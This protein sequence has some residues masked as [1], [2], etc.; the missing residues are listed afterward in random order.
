MLIQIFKLIFQQ[1]QFFL[2]LLLTLLLLLLPKLT[3]KDILFLELVDFWSLLYNA[4]YFNSGRIPDKSALG[5]SSTL[6]FS[7]YF[8]L[9]CIFHYNLKRP[10]CCYSKTCFFFGIDCQPVSWKIVFLCW[11]GRYL[12]DHHFP[13]LLKLLKGR[14]QNFKQQRPSILKTNNNLNGFH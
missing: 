10:Y 13:D 2:E 3:V 14:Q 4:E 1:F 5:D 6:S 12:N 9:L 11:L 8:V 7:C